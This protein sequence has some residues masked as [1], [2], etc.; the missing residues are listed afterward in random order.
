MGIEYTVYQFE[1]SERS[2]DNP[3]SAVEILVSRGCGR[4][5]QIERHKVVLPGTEFVISATAVHLLGDTVIR[6]HSSRD[7]PYFSTTITSAGKPNTN[8]V[9][10]YR[11]FYDEDP[12]IF[13]Y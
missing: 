6:N 8:V 13:G 12:K 3:V 1:D 4:G 7:R 9:A 11:K 5:V 10:R 2:F